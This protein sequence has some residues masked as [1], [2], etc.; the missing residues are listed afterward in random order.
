MDSIVG[1]PTVDESYDVSNA[2]GSSKAD[3]IPK[4]DEILQFPDFAMLEPRLIIIRYFA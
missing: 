4:A 2:E 3:H 1:T